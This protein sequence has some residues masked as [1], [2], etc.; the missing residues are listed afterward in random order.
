MGGSASRY[1]DE[2]VEVY[3]N[4]LSELYASDM[5]N[6]SAELEALRMMFEFEG[7]TDPEFEIG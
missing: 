5:L 1:A 6:L 3:G 2:S 4:I 7:L